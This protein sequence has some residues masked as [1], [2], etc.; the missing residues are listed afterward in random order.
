[1][2][3]ACSSAHYVAFKADPV[4]LAMTVIYLSHRMFS[5][6]SLIPSYLVRQNWNVIRRE[7][8]SFL[9]S[10]RTRNRAILSP[11]AIKSSTKAPD[12]ESVSSVKVNLQTIDKSELKTLLKS[13]GEK[14]F[15]AEQIVN[16]IRENGA[17]SFDQMTNLPKG[18]IQI[19]KDNA[20][21]GSLE[22]AEE[23]FSKD[24][25]VKRLYRLWDGQLIESVLMPYADGRV[26]ACISSQAG[27]AMGCVFC[28]TGQM[29]FSRQL[30]Q[31][32]IFEQVARFA[33]DVK[34]ENSKNRLS[35]VVM[36]GMGEPLANYRNVMGAIKRMNNELGIGARKITVS[37][38]GV[39]PNIRK[40]IDEPIQVRLA[41][42]LHCA[43]DEERSNL[44]PANK[45]YGGLSE[46]MSAVH[47]YTEKTKRRMTF[48]W[49]LI[50]G[51]ND[52]PGVARKLGNL[53]L[54]HKIPNY[55][56]HINVIP[57]NPT[58]GY[59]GSPSGKKRV[60]EF[61]RILDTEF[62]ISCTPRMR[63]GIDIDAGCGQLKSSVKSRED[64]ALI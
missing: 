2:R 46:L 29:G 33:T 48:E 30:T 34:S 63:R 41:V 51:N 5:A 59:S 31:D 14:P 62:G 42:S 24:G 12:R 57:L 32:E 54:E 55:L 10:S 28:A 13:W 35:N 44:L 38:V 7:F 64:A 36:M 58:G 52:T 56:V 21:I 40:L 61:A 45:R 1:M 11:T 43:E 15:R 19:L 23:Q 26:T 39:V 47:E 16:W 53:I 17:T 18:L 49:A 25:T 3:S 60:S 6:S 50:E 9:D 22:I 37:T 27:C 8:S 20:S 4:H